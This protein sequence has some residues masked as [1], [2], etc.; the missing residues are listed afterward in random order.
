MAF[1][2]KNKTITLPTRERVVALWQQGESFKSIASKLGI[3]NRTASNIVTNV[4]ERGHLLALKPGGKERQIAN[5][6]VV[7][8]IEY[9]KLDK[10]NT[11]TVELQAALVHHGVCTP[12]NLAARS[13]ISDILRKDLQYTYKKLRVVPEESRTEA[14]QV[15][16]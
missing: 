11:T 14:N 13:T 5:P 2:Q 8:H 4:A 10:P 3:S 7:E 9:Q 15:R 6:N 16:C 12:E 1:M